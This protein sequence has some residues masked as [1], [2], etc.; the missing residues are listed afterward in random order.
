MPVDTSIYG[1]LA[2]P[3]NP[4]AQLGDFARTKMML[5][6]NAQFQQQYKA[7]MAMGQIMQQSVDPQTGQPDYAK[8]AIMAA[9][10]PDAAWMSPDLMSQAV[11]RQG[12]QLDNVMKQYDVAQ[13]RLGALG[14]V[15][16]SLLQYG[17]GVTRD[18][19]V[20]GVSRYMGAM[21]E[22]GITDPFDL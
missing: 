12:M 5:N 3:P 19:V 8:A 4:I 21:H 18:Q 15:A 17:D 13:K 1:Q 11:Q 14:N 10:N 7:R 20:E 22:Q 2:P 6:A 9:Q 16:G